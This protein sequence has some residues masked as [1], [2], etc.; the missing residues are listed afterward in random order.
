MTMR[1][2]ASLLTAVALLATLVTAPP[3][4]AALQGPFAAPRAAGASLRVVVPLA[5]FALMPF[6]A[7]QEP[8][9]PALVREHGWTRLGFE[10]RDHG[11][12]VYLDVRGRAEF[13]RAEVVFAD[14]AL[15]ALD[16]GRAVRGAGVYRLVE[17]EGER[18]VLCVRLLARARSPQA[19]VDV[20]L[21]R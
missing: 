16:L 15:E 6:R 2:I 21:G 14:G 10:V 7:A 17:F 1:W 19:H 18:E 3:A 13:D 11:L 20:R 8:A 9:T 12:G 5:R 4:G